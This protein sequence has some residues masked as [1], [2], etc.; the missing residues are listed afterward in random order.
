MK[1]TSEQKIEEDLINQLISG[2]SQWIYRDDLRTEEALWANVRL[3]LEQNNRAELKNIPLTEQE[4]RQVKRQ[5]TFLNPY[6]AA[7]WLSGENGKAKVEVQRED[8]SLGVIRLTVINRADIA[9]GTTVYEVINQYQSSKSETKKRDRRFD[10]TLLMNGLPMIH[11][12]LKN[13]QH[14]YMDGFRQIHKYI[15]EGA[16]DPIFS[17]TQMYVISN[18]SDTRYIAAADYDSL[19]ASFLSKWVDLKNRPVTNYID[20]ARDVLSIPQAHR[21]VTQYSVTDRDKEALILLRPYQIHAI[22][23]IKDASKRHDSGYIWHTTGSGKTLT[24][25]KVACN[26]LQIPNIDKT[27]FIVDRVDL[28]QQTTSSFTSYAEF[29]PVSIDE[30]DNVNEL[31]RRLSSDDRTVV[32]TTIQKLNHLMKRMEAE[33][34]S[35]RNQKRYNKI[36]NLKVAFIV[37]ECHRAVTPKKKRELDQYFHYALWY[38]FTGTPIF[39][40]NARAEQ[41]DLARTTEGLYGKRLHEYTVKEAI[42]D[43][44]V[45]GFQVEYK[46]AL[47]KSTR[48]ALVEEM[49]PDRDISYDELSDDDKVKL[50]KSIPNDAYENDKHRLNVIDFIV[51]QSR[52]KLGF[53]AEEGGKAYGAILT[54]SSINSAQEYYDL[55]KSVI[56]GNESVTICDKTRRILPDFPKV[57][58]TYSI[59]ENEESSIRNQEKMSEALED[60]NAR[61]KTNFKIDTIRAYNQDV[62]ARL[63]RKQ[64]RFKKRSEQIDIIIVVDRLLTGFDAPCISTLFIDRPPM[65]LQNIIQSFSRTNRLYDRNKQFGQIV[66]FRTPNYY[67][68]QVK[69][70]LILYSNGGE[71]HVL[72]PSWDEAV[73]RLAEAVINLRAI[74]RT[75]DDVDELDLLDLREFVKIYQ[76]FDSALSS[77]MV[78]FD[79]ADFDIEAELG[80]KEPDI[81][82]YHGKYVNALETIRATT[83]DEEEDPIDLDFELYTHKIEEINY[84]Y[85]LALIQRFVPKDEVVQSFHF[86]PEERVAEVNKYISV[87]SEENP[88]LA[89]LM[90]T[91]WDNIQNDPEAYR[92]QDINDLLDNMI[93]ETIDYLVKDFSKLWALQASELRF[94]V[95]NYDPNREAQNGEAELRHTSNY[96]F[97]KANTEDPVSRL[98]YWRTVKAAYTEMIQNDVLP[99]RVRD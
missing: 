31:I 88:K 54:T 52:R 84:R 16:F 5:L 82:K 17:S 68:Q 37:D 32:V 49:F 3:I 63:A 50:E 10:V 76:K 38:G 24:S 80:L 1:F 48:D 62:N 2:E 9:G 79:Y 8:A 30:T 57:A 67:E 95:D 19:N 45:L 85:I 42:N 86:I 77:A 61:Y 7:K 47:M 87:L 21:M 96:E 14:P 98:R 75:P 36:K 69:E 25:Y 34:I 91:L 72:A 27:I 46:H 15:K 74:A 26:L 11:I 28:D 29:D 70:A 90:R 99:L 22:E 71:S 93:S 6:E 56:A 58:I 4:F 13:R 44:A 39:K 92:G 40:K 81:E 97:Y 53:T 89:G 20:F 94:L 65:S 60:Y 51:N 64:E 66:T 83:P 23:A 18:A 12:E 43:K 78:Y 33:E 41:G 55:F 73:E 35:E 59:S